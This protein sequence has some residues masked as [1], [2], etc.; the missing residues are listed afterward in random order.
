MRSSRGE[1]S[2]RSED[3]FT[4]VLTTAIAEGEILTHITFPAGAGRSGAAYSKMRQQASGMALAGVAARITLDAAGRIEE[5]TVG[6][7]GIGG[8]PFRARSIEQR[9]SGLRPT[10]SVLEESC[11]DVP[12]ADPTND[13]HADADYRRQLLRVHATRALTRALERARSAIP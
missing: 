13:L 2:V 9:L 8:V 1:R 3:F 10:P 4:G 7:T 5:S 11:G 12:E 6:V